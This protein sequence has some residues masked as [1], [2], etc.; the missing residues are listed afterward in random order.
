MI[1][2]TKQVVESIDLDQHVDES[3]ARVKTLATVPQ[4]ALRITRLVEDPDS[5][6]DNLAQVINS[7]PSLC[8]RVLKVVNS[9]YYGMSRS[10]NT[11]HEALVL[12]G[13]NAVNNIAIASSF[14][15]FYKSDQKVPEFDPQE[16]WT[17]SVAVAMAAKEIAEINRLAVVSQAYIAGLIHDIGLIIELQMNAASLAKAISLHTSGQCATLREAERNVFGAS[18]E[19]FGRGACRKW[20]FPPSLESAAGFHHAASFAPQEHRNLTTIVQ[21]ADALAVSCGIGYSG[22][23]EQTTI[24]PDLV[25]SLKLSNEELEGLA[26]SLEDKTHEMETQLSISQ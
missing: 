15:R 5:T 20:N 6:I 8:A 25:R 10:V 22:T 2:T 26:E 19:D 24:D 9:S 12:I 11:I 3:L 21:L 1:Q 13:F 4:A 14:D 7:D 17:H 16:V 18:H 23:Q